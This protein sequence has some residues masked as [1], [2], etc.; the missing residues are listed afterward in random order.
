MAKE[1]L[2]AEVVSIVYHCHVCKSK[3]T[4]GRDYFSDVGTPDKCGT[5]DTPL[6]QE[7]R[8]T[9]NENDTADDMSMKKDDLLRKRGE[10]VPV[11][12]KPD[13][14]EAMKRQRIRELRE[15]AD[16]LERGDRGGNGVR[17]GP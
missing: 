9:R 6:I 16:R 4:F 8:I 15:E 3:H 10:N 2:P 13:D 14:P 7:D 1:T 11:R 12:E 17:L 5:C